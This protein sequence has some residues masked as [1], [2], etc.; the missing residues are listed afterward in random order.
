MWVETEN[1]NLASLKQ[2]LP[3][4]KSHEDAN[5]CNLVRWH[6]KRREQNTRAVSLMP[7]F[8]DASAI[9]SGCSRFDPVVQEV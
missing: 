8:F 2:H 7:A 1:V 4:L 9:Q 5:T 3:A 6:P